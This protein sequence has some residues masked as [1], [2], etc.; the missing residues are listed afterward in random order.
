MKKHIKYL[1]ALSLSYLFMLGE[2]YARAGGGGGKRSS[3]SSSSSSGSWSSGSGHYSSGSGSLSW[4]AIIA[5]VIGLIVVA[6]VVSKLKKKGILSSDGSINL[7][8]TDDDSSYRQKIPNNGAAIITEA[9]MVANPGFNKDGFKEKVRISFMEIQNAWQNQNLGKVRKWI[10][11]G[12][13]QRFNIQFEMMKKLGQKNILSNIKINEIQFVKAQTEASYSIITVG[14]SFTMDDKFISESIPKLNES[15]TGD[16]ATEYW[17]F[18]K[19]SGAVEKDLYSN[20][21]CPNCGDV[22]N[23]DGGEVSKCKSC[24]TVTYLGDYDWV[25]SEITQEDTFDIDSSFDSNDAS[26]A[27]IRA[28]EDF[29]IQNMEDKASNAFV[30]YLFASAWNN[31][32][33][34]ERFA[35]DEVI[36][37]IKKETDEPYVY[38]RIYISDV[39]CSGY[40]INENSHQFTFDISYSGQRVRLKDGKVNFVD[41]DIDDK[42]ATLILAKKIGAQKPKSKL[43]SHECP[44]CAAPYTD[45]T[46]SNCTFCGSKINSTEFDWVVTDV[47]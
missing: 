45:T 15:Y 36:T 1:F 33:H 3:S 44:C 23:E 37:K 43:W 21:N 32:K 42:F 9:F 18:V 39:S 17:T 13:Y 5:I 11:D 20:N 27:T 22:L 40:E 46:S 8:G 14:I 38:N 34:F 41:D 35:T 47:A 16:S 6:I 24:G 12:V 26:L 19:K 10:S 7:G 4:P 2:I 30:Q 29:C 25:L 28:E 31:T